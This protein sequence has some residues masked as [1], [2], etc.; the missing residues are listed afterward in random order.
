[1]FPGVD[2]VCLDCRHLDFWLSPDHL[3]TNMRLPL[4]PRQK[5]LPSENTT[6]LISKE[7]SLDPWFH[8]RQWLGVSG[9]QSTRHLA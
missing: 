4:A 8:K 6:N 5:L 1:M 9:T 2:L 7:L 3:L